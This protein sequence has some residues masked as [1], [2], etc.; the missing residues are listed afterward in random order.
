MYPNYFYNAYIIII[1]I[2]FLIDFIY[3]FEKELD[4]SGD[5]NTGLDNSDVGDPKSSIL[6]SPNSNL[7]EPDG[8]KSPNPRSV[9]RKRSLRSSHVPNTDSSLFNGVA[10]PIQTVDRR[11]L[12]SIQTRAKS[13]PLGLRKKELKSRLNGPNLSPCKRSFFLDGPRP[14]DPPSPRG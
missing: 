6:P 3:N 10:S 1:I 4:N 7:I 14:P 2:S 9:G 12:H 11:R 8:L 13:P 5:S